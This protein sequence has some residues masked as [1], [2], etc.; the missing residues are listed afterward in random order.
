MSRHLMRGNSTKIAEQLFRADTTPRGPQRLSFQADVE[1]TQPDFNEVLW[2]SER[3]RDG[4][5]F[6]SPAG[7][8]SS[9]IGSPPPSV[10]GPAEDPASPEFT[11]SDR[12]VLEQAVASSLRALHGVPFGF[13]IDCILDEPM[14]R[15]TVAHLLTTHSK[16]HD[17]YMRSPHDNCAM[18]FV[19]TAYDDRTEQGWWKIKPDYQFLESTT[20]QKVKSFQLVSPVLFHAGS[21]HEVFYKV[22]AV[23]EML[24]DIGARTDPVGGLHIHLDVARLSI[25]QLKT[26]TWQTV[27]LEPAIDA[28]IPCDR[29]LPRKQKHTQE[30]LESNLRSLQVTSSDTNDIETKDCAVLPKSDTI[31]AAHSDKDSSKEYDRLMQVRSVD[32]LVQVLNPGGRWYKVN[33]TNLVANPPHRQ[34]TLEFRS[35]HAV[36]DPVAVLACAALYASVLKSA[37]STTGLKD[38]PRSVEEGF[39]QLLSTLPENLRP[40]FTRRYLAIERLHASYARNIIDHVERGGRHLEDASEKAL[41]VAAK[42]G[43]EQPRRSFRSRNRDV[44]S[45]GEGTLPP[46][47][48]RKQKYGARTALQRHADRLPTPFAEGIVR[49]FKQKL[50]LSPSTVT[51]SDRMLYHSA[52]RRLHGAALTQAR[53]PAAAP[54]S[55]ATLDPRKLLLSTASLLRTES[56]PLSYYHGPLSVI[57][58]RSFAHRK[59][60]PVITT[61]NALRSMDSEM[62]VARAGGSD[63][64][65]A[66]N[67]RHFVPDSALDPLPPVG[68]GGY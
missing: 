30:R 52:L 35:H 41:Y 59:A 49:A 62:S 40:Y 3:E 57:A 16:N 20:G 63:D 21:P 1:E 23:C 11:L 43:A 27:R 36:L 39:T 53:N 28:L 38:V 9:S 22:H 56:G 25:E 33:A 44:E 6:S 2:R 34:E 65:I 12:V 32:D 26:F 13:E 15:A 17:P 8:I 68:P 4:K 64:N 37:I 46:T 31:A 14:T 7:E 45:Q 50:A 19:P 61:S 48:R 29:W 58:P 42:K 60:F 5:V 66:E 18:Q 47:Q 54:P 55:A 67:N 10:G 24:R 51:P